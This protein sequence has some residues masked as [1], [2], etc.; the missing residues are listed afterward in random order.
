VTTVSGEPRKRAAL[1]DA[2]CRGAGRKD[3]PI[4]SGG[5]HGILKG[6]VQPECGQASVLP[7]FDHRRPEDFPPNTA[8]DFLRQQIHARPGELTLL[9]I[10]P[11]TNLGLLFA[12]DPEVAQKLKRLVLMCGVFTSGTGWGVREWNALCDP[13]ATAITYAA[14]VAEHISIGLDVTTKCQMPSKEC[15]ARFNQIGGP[16][17]VVAAATETW[18]AD[19]ITFHDP[20]AGAV[21]FEPKLCEYQEGQVAVELQSTHVPGMTHFDPKAAQKPHRVAM[22]VYA[23]AFFEHYFSVTAGK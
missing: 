23:S 5:D 12:L 9:A 17:N 3:V 11:M 20:L 18:G 8:V 14:P 4:H 21:I 19:K 16:L 1:A 6:V 10:G 13:I 15:I 7:R 2:V 22:K